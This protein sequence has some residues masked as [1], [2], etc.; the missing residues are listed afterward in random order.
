MVTLPFFFYF[1]IFLFGVVGAMRGW[2]RELLVAFSIVLAIFIIVVLQNF[3][4]YLRDFLNPANQEP[5]FWIRSTIIA[6]FTFFGYQ[7]P[8]LSERFRTAARREK[9]QDSL[10][11]F[12]LGA[13]NGYLIIGTIW[14]FLHEAG[15][16]FAEIIAPVAGTELGDRTLELINLMPP[17]WLGVPAVYFAV[18]VAFAF[19][20]IVFI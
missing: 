12:V 14:F 9:L 6:I 2:A 5:S 7:T 17:R 11:G 3:A 19:V 10:L 16:P 15:Y 4:P 20:V 8:N 18:A 13:V 1:L